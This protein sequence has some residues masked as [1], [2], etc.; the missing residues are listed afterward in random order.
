MQL[1]EEHLYS[2]EIFSHANTRTDGELSTTDGAFAERF[3]GIMF[4]KAGL[5]IMISIRATG[6]GPNDG[7]ANK[8]APRFTMIQQTNY[9]DDGRRIASM[10]GITLATFAGGGVQAVPVCIE[11]VNDAERFNRSHPGVYARTN[12]E[13]PE[14]VISRLG[15]GPTLNAMHG[16]NQ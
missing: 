3:T 1:L 4:K 15:T 13:I 16:L 11:R 6:L 2:R 8:G 9:M 14:D 12:P 7:A 5:P 10:S